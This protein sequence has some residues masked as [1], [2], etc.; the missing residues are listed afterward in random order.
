MRILSITLFVIS[1]ILVLAR[2]KKILGIYS[3]P[4]KSHQVLG[5]VILKKLAERG[6]NITMVSAYPLKT[7]VENYKDVFLDGFLEDINADGSIYLEMEKHDLQNFMGTYELIRRFTNKTFAHPA[8]QSLIK[9]GDK[10]DLIVMDWFCKDAELFYGNI[11][12]APIILTS[13]F[14]T[15]NELNYLIN[16]PEPYS[17]VPASGFAYTD[18]MGF[19]DRLG[20]TLAVLFVEAFLFRNEI[21][22]QMILDRYFD[23]APRIWE[24]RRNID[25]IFTNAHPTFETP[26][27]Y[28]PNIIPI[29]GV[30][31]QEPQ[32]L[33]L[34]IQE[35]LDS[36]QN[37]AVYFSLGSHMKTSE[38]P[39]DILY[40]I[41]RA[42][43]KV[44]QKVLLKWEKDEKPKLPLN[45]MVG[46]WMPQNSIL[47]HPNVKVFITH[48]GLMSKIEAIH[49]A[50]PMIGIPVFGDQKTNVIHSVQ[51]GIAVQ[52]S[53]SELSE[54][55]LVSAINEIIN[56]SS[57][58]R[59]IQK[60]SNL[61][62]DQPM[63]P[64]D[65][66]IYWAEFVMR[67]NGSKHLQNK[68]MRLNKFQ[69]LLLDVALTLIGVLVLIVFIFRKVFVF[70]L[71]LP[72]SATVIRT[73]TRKIKLKEN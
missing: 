22:Q 50:T 49:Y 70:A 68:S 27:P 36:A 25:L 19:L 53:L 51:E 7:P 23:N 45:V 55:A 42:F 38:L 65:T 60:K 28:L 46:K 59:N 18:E 31:V 67:H 12:E 30:H 47:A 40:N 21:Q 11:F 24:L 26:R 62:R 9:S 43:S 48:G 34:N 8:M 41:V 72:I 58:S 2:C 39:E 17:Y 20:N 37:G 10:F 61:L 3:H 14:G 66:A 56:N 73:R 5:E 52:L 1:E 57:Y 32:L 44:Q 6:H 13:S 63:V 4:G 64:I 69:N 16:N 71:K 15:Q 35:F 29:G 33:P 54:K